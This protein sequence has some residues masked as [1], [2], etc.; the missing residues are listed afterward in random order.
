[1]Q[2]DCRAFTLIELLVVIAIIALLLAILF[3]ALATA[4][5]RARGTACLSNCRQM[6]LALIAY[7]QDYDEYLW[8][9]PQPGDS[10][11]PEYCPAPECGGITF[12]TEILHPYTRNTGIFQCPSN[13]DALYGPDNYPQ[14]PYRVTYGFI[15][16]GP[17]ADRMQG[18]WSL[19]QFND[20]T[21]L[22]LLC[23]AVYPW[24]Y[25][26]C[27]P[28]PRKPEGK[29]SWYFTRGINGWEF[30]GQ[31]RHFGGMNFVYADGHARLGKP[32]PSTQ[33]H[34]LNYVGEY[35]PTA[36]ALERDCT[37]FQQ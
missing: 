9:N 37:D 22:A 25:S 14:P 12:W 10:V 17:L 21:R 13:D 4:R 24:N 30:F 26:N 1:M 15:S 23:D 36:V 11:D 2:P 27:E 35:Y 7:A 6:G 32:S 8:S 19:A 16:D 29:G 20:V 34:P 18:A 3:P 31:V 5:E 33:P 28:D